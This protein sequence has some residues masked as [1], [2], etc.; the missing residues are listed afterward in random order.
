MEIKRTNTRRIVAVGVIA[1]SGLVAGAPA[2]A[3][4]ASLRKA[5]L[6][7]EKKVDV[8]VDDFTEAGEDTVSAVGRERANNALSDLLTTVKV[9]RAAVVKQKATTTRIKRARTQYLAAIDSFT[10][11]LKTFDQGLE[12]FDPDAPAKSRTLITKATTQ[13]DSAVIRRER[14]RK[15]IV[16]RAA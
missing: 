11:G 10:T 13:L 7:Q 16:R 14:A 8:V 6:A 5:V 2:L 15:L 3:S 4:D 12:A 9:Q 1:A